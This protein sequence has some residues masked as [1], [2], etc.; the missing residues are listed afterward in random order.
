MAHPVF[1]SDFKL[2]ASVLPQR[3]TSIYFLLLAQIENLS[4]N[5]SVDHQ[6]IKFLV[7]SLK[8][9]ILNHE[10]SLVLLNF[11]IQHAMATPGISLEFKDF[12]REAS[13]AV[14]G[15]EYK[16]PDPSDNVTEL[17]LEARIHRQ[18]ESQLAIHLLQS[19]TSNMWASIN[20]VS[21]I[22][23]NLISKF[24]GSP[25]VF[26]TFLVHIN[27]KEGAPLEPTIPLAF[28]HFSEKKNLDDVIE[29]L[30]SGTDL[31]AVMLIQFMFMRDAFPRLDIPAPLLDAI[32]SNQYAGA[33]QEHLKDLA[34]PRESS[35]ITDFFTQF[36]SY[37]PELYA[38]RGR[39][40]FKGNLDNHLGIVT[41]EADRH[42]MPTRTTSWYPD[43]I[44]QAPNVNS[45]YVASL[46][47]HDIPYVAGPSGMTA[48]LMGA[49]A[50]LGN[51]TTP[52]EKNY[53]IL[54]VLAFIVGGGLHSIHEVLSVPNVLLGLVPNY[55]VSDEKMGNF[56]AF[57][58]SFEADR[59]VVNCLDN[60][61]SATLDWLNK[62]Y[63]EN[64]PEAAR[65]IDRVVAP[66]IDEHSSPSI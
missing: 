38:D 66:D 64:S 51:F 28:S 1:Q 17:D 4:P 8:K 7:A 19:P 58:S 15:T 49:L 24:T 18:M 14:K 12:L 21:A 55:H 48:I 13:S 42:L 62:T 26:K 29:L 20:R 60:A 3:E 5:N 44:C 22:I 11:N 6:Q 10:Q 56:D 47:A 46:V 9:S 23:I 35:Q 30:A 57:F 34:S 39:S 37:V 52:Q 54:S 32:D 16:K 27:G 40:V 2:A 50:L 59:E 33:F 36:T 25:E 41:H 65:V 31:A 43:S 53:Y 61:W 45:A 63:L